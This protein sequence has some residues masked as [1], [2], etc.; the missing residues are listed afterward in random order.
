MKK[1]LSLNLAVLILCLFCSLSVSAQ[2]KEDNTTNAILFAKD[3]VMD[4]TIS[5]NIKELLNDRSE[6]APFRP[7]NL[8]YKNADGSETSVSVTLKTRGHF[9]KLKQNCVYPPLLIQFIKNEQLQ[10]SIFKNQEKLK[11]VMPCQGD[12][13]VIREWLVY[14]LYNLITPLSFRAKLVRV[15]LNDTKNNKVTPPFYSIILEDEKQVVKRNNLVS[16]NRKMNPNETN[17]AAFLTMSVFEYMIANTDWSVQYLQN[18]K[19]MSTD[20]VAV[21]ITVPYDFDHSGM[22]NAPYAKP[23]EELEMS[24][25]RERRYRGY[26]IPDLK[27]FES[28][29]E[30][31]NL[32]KN[33]IYK[34]YT[35]CTLLDAKYIK[36]TIQY[37]DEFY[38]TINTA[39]AWQKD[40]AYPCDK[41]GTGDVVVKGL[42]EE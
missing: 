34:L 22:V 18:I 2:L 30:K 23:V 12:E 14:K 6:N 38:S 17:A 41:N 4:I 19:L 40:F 21:P 16:I 33:D 29:I 37:M 9:R 5:G 32:L 28:I 20:S 36:S 3:E 35:E 26:C 7:Q 8:M 42:K 31:F 15:T 24:S 11:L 27:V 39:K 25:V 1:C 13:Y 10:S